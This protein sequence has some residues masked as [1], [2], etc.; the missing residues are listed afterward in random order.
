M[1]L[2]IG[3]TDITF[4]DD[5]DIRNGPFNLLLHADVELELE[6]ERWLSALVVIHQDAV[7]NPVQYGPGFGVA[8][9]ARLGG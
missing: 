8:L 3:N 2:G 1:T 5:G 9:T 6:F 4:N 7:A